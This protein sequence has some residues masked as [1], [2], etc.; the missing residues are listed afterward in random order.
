MTTIT[1]ANSKLSLTIRSSAGVAIVGPFTLEGYATDD[2]FAVEAVESGIA[3]KGVDGRMSA[4]FVPFVT[5]QTIMLQADSPSIQLFDD[6]M[7]AEQALKDKLY[8]DGALTQPGP[9]KAY[10]MVKGVLTRY[11]TL[12]AARRTLE[13]VQ[14]QITWDQVNPTPLVL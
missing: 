11:T 4:G 14:Y 3:K 13:P 5:V 2:A 7:A 10:V 12:A 9:Q 8:A 1:S 6:W